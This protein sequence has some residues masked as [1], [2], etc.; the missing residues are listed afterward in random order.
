MNV[1]RY[2][3]ETYKMMLCKYSSCRKCYKSCCVKAGINVRK[4]TIVC[5]VLAAA[6]FSG[7]QNSPSFLLDE[8]RYMARLLATP[9]SVPP[10]PGPNSS[11]DGM[12]GSQRGK[13][14]RVALV[15]GRKPKIGLCTEDKD[16]LGWMTILKYKEFR[17]VQELRGLEGHP[18]LTF[19]F[20]HLSAASQT[21]WLICNH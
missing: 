15:G 9:G 8:P 17:P 20:W 1:V 5:L 12:L 21:K 2:A 10:L 7:N 14:V 6:A 19:Q 13:P 11:M 18:I 16:S 4:S 3:Y